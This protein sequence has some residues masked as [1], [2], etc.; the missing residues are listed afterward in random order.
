MPRGFR[1]RLARTACFGIRVLW[2]ER[3]PKRRNFLPPSDGPR[4]GRDHDHPRSADR[5][6][7]VE[8]RRHPWRDRIGQKHAAPAR[9]RSGR[10]RE[11]G[12][13]GGPRRAMARVP[14]SG[15]RRARRR[16]TAERS[17]AD[18]RGA[19]LRRRDAAPLVTYPLED[20]LASKTSRICRARSTSIRTGAARDAT[21]STPCSTMRPSERS[22][23][24]PVDRRE[25]P[26]RVRPLRP[27]PPL[28]CRRFFRIFRFLL[29][30]KP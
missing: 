18:R 30:P 7:M 24:C 20:L 2:F 9:P 19:S 11:C 17:T 12:A 15:C 6:G 16:R 25:R 29:P 14:A 5:G 28:R 23:A 26:L 8:R 21:P 3:K 1:E 10:S 13:R 27:A 4:R 22:P